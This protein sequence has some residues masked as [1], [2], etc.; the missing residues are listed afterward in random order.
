V[1]GV[2]RVLKCP[3]L[4][5]LERF[6][7]PTRLMVAFDGSANGR[8]NVERIAKHPLVRGMQCHVVMAND[9]KA[10]L[11]DKMLTWA[12]ATLEAQG[13]ETVTNVAIGEAI[14]MLRDYA[15]QHAIDLMVTG[16][17]GHS[18]LR[19]LIVGSTTTTLLRT[20]PVPVLVLR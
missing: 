3:V 5:T 10:P 15:R 17:F 2:I 4:A 18:M 14:P 12:R 11:I 7:A 9:R 6:S 19:Q 20:S 13:V 8:S 16:A 1:E